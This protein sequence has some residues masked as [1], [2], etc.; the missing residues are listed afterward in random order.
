MESAWVPCP[1]WACACHAQG[2]GR[3]PGG[4]SCV[5]KEGVPEAPLPLQL[6]FDQISRN[7]TS[8]MDKAFMM[9]I[10]PCAMVGTSD[11]VR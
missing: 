9:G 8:Y 6:K 3:G 1:W 5:R 10:R 7:N 2:A 11:R 4:W